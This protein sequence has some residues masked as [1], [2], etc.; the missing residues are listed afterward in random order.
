LHD[1]HTS[2]LRLAR[3]E[4]NS[5]VWSHLSCASHFEPSGGMQRVGH[6]LS[7]ASEFLWQYWH[8]TH[9]F[10]AEQNS[11]AALQWRWPSHLAAAPAVGAQ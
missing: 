6:C 4:Q 1:T 5:L 10:L 8:G 2:S 7:T 3:F 9:S 11:P